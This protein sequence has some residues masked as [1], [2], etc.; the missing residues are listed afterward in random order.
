L[1]I[2]PP[3]LPEI[4]PEPST[5][6]AIKVELPTQPPLPQVPVKTEQPKVTELA[7]P[8]VTLTSPPTPQPTATPILPKIENLTEPMKIAPP[9]SITPVVETKPLTSVVPTVEMPNLT[10]VPVSAVAP[11]PTVSSTAR[12][13]YDVD[14]HYVKGGDS[15]GGVS[16]QY[17]GDERYAEALRSYN[18]NANLNQM[19]RAEVPPLHVLRK[20]YPTLIAAPAAKPV[21]WGSIAPA[22]A[23]SSPS[24]E[25]AIGKIT[26]GGY[27]TY[28]VPVNGQTI[29][30]IALDA[31]GDEAL[32][33]K[34]WDNNPKLVTDRLIEPGT[35]IFLTSD[36]K[37]GN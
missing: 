30:Q 1:A 13:D 26:S 15:W 12:T 23:K 7:V 18:Q 6:A 25:G 17:Y 37:I 31:Y 35:K 22:T 2:D 5:P 14:L 27:K 8:S 33:G 3:K 32:W 24:T 20:N 11:Q 10:A 34:V 9:A 19:Q 16:K 28:I 29:R 36:S 4:K 21:E